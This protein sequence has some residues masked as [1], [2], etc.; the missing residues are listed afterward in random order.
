[1]KEKNTN[2]TNLHTLILFT[3]PLIALIICI[4]MSAFNL[5][6]LSLN[7]IPWII[8]TIVC[9]VLLGFGS[10]LDEHCCPE[11]GGW[12][13][14]SKDEEKIAS[15]REITMQETRK[16]Q[17]YSNHQKQYGDYQTYTVNVPGVEYK[18]NINYHCKRCGSSVTRQATKQY[19]H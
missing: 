17:K 6:T 8:A 7:F 12:F 18:I 5:F 19:K 2:R 1:M 14:L 3:L 11:C 13:C 4:I 10:M 16:T 15:K 9:G